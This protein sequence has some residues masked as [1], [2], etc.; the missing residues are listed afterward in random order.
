MPPIQSSKVFS[1]T[2]CCDSHQSAWGCPE[3]HMIY[4]ANV[5]RALSDTECAVCLPADNVLPRIAK[6]GYNA[7]Q[8]MAI[9]EHAYYASFGYHV[10]NPFAVSSRSGNPEE[11]KVSPI[12]TALHS[13]HRA[14]HSL[15]VWPYRSN[16]GRLVERPSIRPR[17]RFTRI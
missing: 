8:L 6:L 3:S 9:Q 16:E 1:A 17:C 15:K 13:W 7:I 2:K 5:C 4:L 10:T 14:S 12:T 11:L